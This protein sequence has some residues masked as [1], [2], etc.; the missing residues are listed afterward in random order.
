MEA[1][2]FVGPNTP[3]TKRG[4]AC[5]LAVS[6]SARLAG[7]PGAFAVKLVDDVLQPVIGLG[8]RRRVKGIRLDDVGAGLQ[9]G[10]VDL[11]DDVGLGERKEIVVPFQVPG[12]VAEAFAAIAR[13]VQP[14]ALDHRPHRPVEKEDALVEKTAEFARKVTTRHSPFPSSGASDVGRAPRTWLIA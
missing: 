7:E 12:G 14:I 10:G 5:V 13:F 1:V 6:A 2:R 9:I 11:A 3:A 8:D 4:F